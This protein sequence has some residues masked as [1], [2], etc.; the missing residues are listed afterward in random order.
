MSLLDFVVI[1]IASAFVVISIITLMNVF[2]FTRLRPKPAPAD[3]KPFV[4]IMIPARNE[5]AVIGE[6]IRRI[7][8]QDYTNFELFV[9][10]DDSDDGTAKIVREAAGDDPRVTILQGESLPSGW[11]GKNWAC[12]QMSKQARG[13]LL[14]FTDADVRWEPAALS[15]L[16]AEMQRTRTDLYTVWPTQHTETWSE[17]LV[18]PLMAFAIGA[19]L[20]VIGTYHSPFAAFGAAC[21][22]CMVWKR[23]TYDKTGGHAAVRDNVLEDVTLARMVMT[24]GGRLHMADGGGVIGARMYQDWPSVRN[25]YAKNILAGYGSVFALLLA[26]VFHWLLFLFPVAWLAFGWFFNSTS[27]PLVPLTLTAAGITIRAL[28]A[29]FSHQRVMDALFMPVSVLLMTVIATHS[30]RWHYTG[31]PRWKGRTVPSYTDTET[32]DKT[33]FNTE[34]TAK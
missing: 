24:G 6:T 22:Q 30:I 33:L 21:G 15:T 1:F 17:R 25:G 28:T 10:D 20:P 7:L 16:L 4:S 9:L 2:T 11:L 13:D 12:H 14:L 3:F 19:Y 8:A 5:A 31:G 23:D 18:V 32:A 27:W 34:S 29:A 26:T